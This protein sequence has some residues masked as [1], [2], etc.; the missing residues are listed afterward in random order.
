MAATK[1][2][3]V[4]PAIV[5]PPVVADLRKRAMILDADV[6]RCWKNEEE[7]LAAARHDWNEEHGICPNCA[8]KG[9]VSVRE[10]L[11]YFFEFH[12]V[13]CGTCNGYVNPMAGKCPLMPTDYFLAL[14]AA[15]K[16]MEEFLGLNETVR[17]G[18]RVVAVKGRKVAPGTI[19]TV[20]RMGVGQ[21]GP[22][23]LCDLQGGG[24]EFIN[25]ENLQVIATPELVAVFDL[26]FDRLQALLA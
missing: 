19:A 25:P 20:R 7:G 5:L 18:V 8:G 13:T 16:A 9:L 14:Q 22:W 2:R 10:T 26:I 17:Q 3:K 12:T 4:K 24:S 21:F 11:D 1:K 6:E 15:H 23:A